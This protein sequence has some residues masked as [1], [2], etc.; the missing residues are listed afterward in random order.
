MDALYARKRKIFSKHVVKVNDDRTE[1]RV[2]GS[3]G[4][5]NRGLGPTKI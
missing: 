4:N 1:G 3:R 2:P 5:N